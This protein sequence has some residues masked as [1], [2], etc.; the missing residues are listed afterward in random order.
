MT[1]QVALLESCLCAWEDYWFLLSLLGPKFRDRAAPEGALAN[2]HRLRTLLL[3]QGVSKCSPESP[4]DITQ[5]MPP[6]DIA[7][8]VPASMANL[9]CLVAGWATHSRRIY[10]MSGDTQA[11]LKATSLHRMR[12]EDVSLPFPAFGI[13]LDTPFK[14]PDGEEFSL[15]FLTT[16]NTAQGETWLVQSFSNRCAEYKPLPLML[17]QQLKQKFVRGKH[18]ELQA[19]VAKLMERFQCIGGYSFSLNPAERRE[20]VSRTTGR[21]AVQNKLTTGATQAFEQMLRVVVGLTLYLKALPPGSPHLSAWT[22]RH[23]PKSLDRR[24]VTTEAQLCSVSSIYQLT[25]AERA[26]LLD[27]RMPDEHLELAMSTH[28]RTA[29][30]RRVRGTGY[31]PLAPRVEH[32]RWTIVRRDRLPDSGGLPHGTTQVL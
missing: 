11:I 18:A 14:D 17:R 31:D 25:T 9:P 23:L 26:M 8:E 29:Y 13:E 30:W 5:F 7:A 22:K 3:E 21:L 32:V 1:Y 27:G 2:H 10:R 12:W 20:L 19:T 6:A 28:F 24:A 16:V 4:L 15:V